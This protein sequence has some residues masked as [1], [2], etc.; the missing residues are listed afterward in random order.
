MTLRIN[1]MGR[2]QAAAASPEI[3]QARIAV[4]KATVAGK[5]EQRLA[6]GLVRMEQTRQLARG[7]RVRPV[8]TCTVWFMLSCGLGLSSLARS[9][10]TFHF[11][12]HA[13]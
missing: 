6:D 5:P 11:Y 13:R 3:R 12:Q 10:N 4:H 1:Q 2:M 7:Q 9:M 8:L